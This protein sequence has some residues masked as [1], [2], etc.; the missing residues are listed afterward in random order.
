MV[1]HVQ[2]AEL[3]LEEANRY[4]DHKAAER[5]LVHAILALTAALKEKKT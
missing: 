2:E 4:N 1:D 5:A 3:Q